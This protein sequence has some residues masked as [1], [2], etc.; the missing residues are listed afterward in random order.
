MA[1]ESRVT[2]QHGR[3]LPMSRI[4][5]SESHVDERGMLVQEHFCKPASHVQ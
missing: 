3:L 5:H 2:C 1:Y 4:A